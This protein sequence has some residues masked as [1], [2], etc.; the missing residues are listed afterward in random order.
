MD[1]FV[2]LIEMNDSN[3]LMDDSNGLIGS[4]GWTSNLCDCF[5]FLVIDL[6]I[7]DYLCDWFVLHHMYEISRII[8]RMSCI[9][10]GFC[11][12]MLT[13]DWFQW[14]ID[15]CFI[16]WLIYYMDFVH[17]CFIIWFQ[18]IIDLCFIIWLIYYM[19][20]VHICFII[21][22]IICSHICSHYSRIV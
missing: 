18:W 4:D 16:I 12:Y 3:G 22:F 14:I 13:Y 7:F 9:L 21:W 20:F 19:D 5:M 2:W 11:A 6:A 1:L 15:L 8:D 17:I 10:Y